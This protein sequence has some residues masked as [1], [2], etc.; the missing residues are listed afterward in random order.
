MESQGPKLYFEHAQDDLNLQI[1]R[2]FQDTFS[3][4]T[5]HK[6]KYLI[7]HL[8]QA[9]VEFCGDLCYVYNFR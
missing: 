7:I 9:W 2:M 4:D 3:L 5:A 8:F 1:L 6:S